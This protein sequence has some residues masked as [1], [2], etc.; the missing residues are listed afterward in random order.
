MDCCASKGGASTLAVVR[1]TAAETHLNQ[2]GH[3]DGCRDGRQGK[4]L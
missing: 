1:V 3:Q 4:M 2:C